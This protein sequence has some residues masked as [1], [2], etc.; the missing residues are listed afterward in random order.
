MT[1][2]RQQP[3]LCTFNSDFLPFF[4]ALFTVFN[5]ISFHAAE[6]YI[7][8]PVSH[9][10]LQLGTHASVSICSRLAAAGRTCGLVAAGPRSFCIVVAGG[11]G[12]QCTTLVDGPPQARAW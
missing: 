11:G 7:S 10:Q 1:T 6:L 3:N 4:Q 9:T 12:A 5:V 2:S 8:L